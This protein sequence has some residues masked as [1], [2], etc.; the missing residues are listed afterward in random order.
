ME[1]FVMGFDDEDGNHWELSREDLSRCLRGQLDLR[2]AYLR[3]E[4]ILLEEDPNGPCIRDQHCGNTRKNQMKHR[5]D[6]PFP[7]LAD[8]LEESSW[9]S[10]M[11]FSC[12]TRLRCVLHNMTL[13]IWR[14]LACT[15]QVNVLWPGLP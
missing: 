6:H 12:Q 15:F 13:E 7:Y 9:F 1:N 14:Q 2:S 3:N 8:P 4:T 10:E 11:C 5:H